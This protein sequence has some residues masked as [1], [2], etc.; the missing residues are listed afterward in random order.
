MRAAPE[1]G[2]TLASRWRTSVGARCE[3]PGALQPAWQYGP[4]AVG[5]ETPGTLDAC[6]RLSRLSRVRAP[7]RTI[8]AIAVESQQLATGEVDA[9]HKRLVDSAG[10]YKH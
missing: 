2:R 8:V 9:L 10:G 4:P 7:Q 3:T 6:N 1:T 5:P